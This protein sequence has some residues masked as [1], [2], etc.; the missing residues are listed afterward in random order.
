MRQKKHSLSQW[1][2]LYASAAGQALAEDLLKNGLKAD[3]FPIKEADLAAITRNYSAILF[4]GALGICIRNI[5]PHLRDKKSD[6]ALL[7]TDVQGRFVQTV[8]G[9]HQADANRLTQKLA[10]RLGALPVLST[11]SES[12]NLWPL[13]LLARRFG[14][15][16]EVRGNLNQLM[17]RFVNGAPTA[18]LLEA[19]D[20]GTL[21]LENS[22]PD[23]VTCFF[24]QEDLHPETFELL[25]VVSPFTRFDNQEGIFFRPPILYLGVGCQKNISG[26]LLYETIRDSLNQQQLSPLALAGIGSISHKKEEKALK[27]LSQKFEVPLHYFEADTLRKHTVPHPSIRAEKETGSPS[28]AEAAACE[29]AQNT[30][31]VGKQK[32]KAGP[33]S[34]TIALALS[35]Q[36]ERK[37]FV[38]FVGAGPGHPDLITVMGQKLIRTADLLLYAGSLVPEILT[39]E[40]KPGCLVK[41]SAEMDLPGQVALMKEFCDRKLQVVRLHTGDP[42]IYGAIQEQMAILDQFAIPY[43]I[44][45][46][47]SSFQAAAAMLK[48]QFTIPNGTQT[49][50]LSRVA[51]KTP[52][53]AAESLTNLAKSQSTLCLFLSAAMAAQIQKDLLQSY[54]AHTPVAICHKLTWPEQKIIRCKLNQLTEKMQDSELHLTTL[55]VV[56]QAID[57]RKGKSQLYHPDFKHLFRP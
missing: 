32:L 41:N 18:L 6:P 48:S 55:L 56:G 12:L 45:P 2:V 26:P 46:G 20:S 35:S 36:H 39:H 43:A 52:T 21:Y 23:H 17:A 50:I 53:P 16:T 47:V 24:Q 4:I 19:R 9:G 1:A 29:M 54:P 11:A 40:V 27:V 31:L 25:I 5:V 3:V 10:A 22:L 14:W 30:L 44:V 57:N 8:L 49:I 7:N 33:Q 15:K 42:C 37:G 38:H 51:G 28:V 13:D 34:A